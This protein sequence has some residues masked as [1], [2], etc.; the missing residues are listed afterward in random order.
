MISFLKKRNLRLALVGG[1]IGLCSL[2]LFSGCSES[3]ATVQLDERGWPYKLV[4]GHNPPEEET[5]RLARDE[6]Y[7]ALS[8]YL[9]QQLD[10]EVEVVKIGSYNVAIE[11]MRASKVDI[12]NFGSFSYLIAH[13]K[14]DAEPLVLRGTKEYGPGGYQSFLVTAADSPLQTIEDV[15][16]NLDKL[17]M[18]FNDPASTSGHLVPRGFFDSKGVVPER[19]FKQVV[20]AMSHTANVMT[21][22][23]GKTDLAAV[24]SSTFTRM[25]ERGVIKEDEVR[26]L[27]KSDWMPNGPI[28]V[29]SSLPE[30]F[31]VALQDAYLS[32]SE[33][34]PKTWD[35]VRSIYTN[36]DIVFLPGD[37]SVFDYYREIARNIEHMR[38]LD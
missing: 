9:E 31:K 34:S 18:S 1:L 15:F 8:E 27:W 12:V 16:D 21:A 2:A 6:V 28:T 33:K 10:V 3:S 4:I 7:D 17:T 29:R 13:Q 5:E 22:I 20:F 38:L 26:V 36:P 19:D 23:S 37:D 24:A 11:A 14:A 35:K 32:M 25:I 30:D